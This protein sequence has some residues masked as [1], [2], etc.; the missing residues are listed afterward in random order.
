MTRKLEELFELPPAEDAPAVDAASPPVEDLRTQL[1]NLD[2]TIDKVDAALPGV[3]GLE[4]SD[5][6][7]RCPP[8]P[9]PRDGEVCDSNSP[10]FCRWVL[11]HC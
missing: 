8:D 7:M 2:D 9:L 4:S 1:Q 6:E 11:M 3:R 10:A 5:E